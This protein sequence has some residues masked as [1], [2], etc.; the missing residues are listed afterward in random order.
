MCLKYL[1]IR[2]SCWNRYLRQNVSEIELIESQSLLLLIILPLGSSHS[3]SNWIEAAE[4]DRC[5]CLVEFLLWR[6]HPPVSNTLVRATT[7]CCCCC[8][9][10]KPAV[11]NFCLRPQPVRVI[12]QTLS[13]TEK[14][15][16]FQDNINYWG[17]VNVMVTKQLGGIVVCPRSFLFTD[18]KRCLSSLTIAGT[19][20][21][22]ALFFQRGVLH[23]P[24]QTM[25]YVSHA[26]S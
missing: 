11:R 19:D 14:S 3:T 20:L 18:G 4:G 26:L 24:W 8:C 10:F 2:N 21:S 12:T 5:C 13:G 15:P 23:L 1:Y 22:P 17:R 16:K 6:P 7:G 25:P 9:F